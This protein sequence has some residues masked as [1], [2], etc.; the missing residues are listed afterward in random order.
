VDGKVRKR[1]VFEG[2][3]EGDDHPTRGADDHQH[4]RVLKHRVLR[5]GN[6]CPWKCDFDCD[7]R[8]EHAA[9]PPA[10]ARYRERDAAVGPTPTDTKEKVEEQLIGNKCSHCHH[11]KKPLAADD[12]PLRACG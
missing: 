8:H 10:A 2:E 3:A 12:R 11:E 4:E 5:G 1:C 6:G 7:G 9:R